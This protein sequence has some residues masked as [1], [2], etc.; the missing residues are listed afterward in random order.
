MAYVWGINAGAGGELR[1]SFEERR[2][3]LYTTVS[4]T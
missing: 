2:R 1:A 4:V 3:R